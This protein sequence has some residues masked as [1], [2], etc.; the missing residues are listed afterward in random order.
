MSE[1]KIPLW[2]WILVSVFLIWNLMGVMAFFQHMSIAPEQ[3]AAMPEA[4]RNLYE[5]NP[6]W[7]KIAF[8]FAVFGGALGCLLMLLKRKIASAVLLLS[9]V[10][11]VVQMFHSFFIANSM[12]V[13][14]PGSVVMPIMVVL[15][16]IFLVWFSRWSTTKGWLA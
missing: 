6:L 16:A 4:E 10:G 5:T 11:V 9:L 12:E 3:I 1:N 15:I 7:A 13:Y 14:G 2:F 8:A